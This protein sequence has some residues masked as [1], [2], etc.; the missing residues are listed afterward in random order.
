MENIR[1][2]EEP[3]SEP[4]DLKESGGKPQFLCKRVP[5]LGSE[6]NVS[7]LLRLSGMHSEDGDSGITP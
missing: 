5:D 4:R 1:G 7:G 6:L 3:D 2:K